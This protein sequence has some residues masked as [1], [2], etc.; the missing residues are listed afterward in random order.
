MLLLLPEARAPIVVTALEM[1]QVLNPKLGHLDADIVDLSTRGASHSQPRGLEVLICP[2]LLR[3]GS[4]KRA[5][6]VKDS[7]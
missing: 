6:L 5:L 4:P 2:L 7:E 3:G 1:V